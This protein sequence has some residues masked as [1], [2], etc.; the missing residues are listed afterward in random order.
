MKYVNIIGI[1]FDIIG[2]LLMFWKTPH[3]TKVGNVGSLMAYI[4]RQIEKGEQK[5][6]KIGLYFLLGGFFLQLIAAIFS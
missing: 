5:W 3:P 1:T 6:V 2:A 4:Q